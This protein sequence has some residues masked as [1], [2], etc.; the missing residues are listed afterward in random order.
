MSPKLFKRLAD[1]GRQVVTWVGMVREQQSKTN[2]LGKKF[3][4]VQT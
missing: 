4:V 1:T 3:E 2:M